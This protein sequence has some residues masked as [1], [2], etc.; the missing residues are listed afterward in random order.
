MAEGGD[1]GGHGGSQC[2]VGAMRTFR[3]LP[4]GALALALLLVPAACGGGRRVAAPP[5]APPTTAAPASTTTAAPVPAPV[6]TTAA[7]PTSVDPGSLPQTAQLPSATDPAL[8][9]RLQALVEAVATGD[10]A[11]ARPAFFPLGAYVQV[12][13]ISDPV[14]DYDT[15]LI[16]DFAQDIMALHHQLDPGGLAARYESVYV[17]DSAVWVRPGVEYNK[18]SYWRVY[19]STVHLTV[20]GRFES[21]TVVSMISWR[22]QWY[23]VH[24]SAIR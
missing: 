12:K 6:A 4:V 20:A 18:G 5:P 1:G 3:R 21:F 15:R 14:H 19:D 13:G 11:V 2:T 16:P 23:V 8:A 17:P 9:V 24:L 7:P 10:P 22:G